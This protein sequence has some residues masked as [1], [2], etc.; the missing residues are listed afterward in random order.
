MVLGKYWAFIF[1]TYF[2]FNSFLCATDVATDTNKE[3]EEMETGL[4]NQLP[5]LRDVRLDGGH[6]DSEVINYLSSLQ[7]YQVLKLKALSENLRSA[8]ET[9]LKDSRRL[10][11]SQEI[12]SQ[13]KVVQES[14]KH[15]QK[16]LDKLASLDIA[17]TGRRNE[18][19]KSWH[20]IFA[21]RNSAFRAFVREVLVLYRMVQF[22]ENLSLA[23]AR[24]LL[25]THLEYV[26]WALKLLPHFPLVSKLIVQFFKPINAPHTPH[27][28]PKMH[29]V[30]D[31][32]GTGLMTIVPNGFDEESLR[33]FQE[34]G[35]HIWVMNHRDIYLDPYFV[36]QVL[37]NAGCGW[38][39]YYAVD[40]F[41]YLGGTMTFISEKIASMPDFLTVGGKSAEAIRRAKRIISH[42]QRANIFIF[43]EATTSLMG[44]TA[45][46]SPYFMLAFI[47]N[48][49]KAN[50]PGGIHL[51]VISTDIEVDFR[52][53]LKQRIRQLFTEQKA[54][55]LKYLGSIDIPD[56]ITEAEAFKINTIIWALIY[57]AQRTNKYH[58][59]GEL[60]YRAL[61]KSINIM[62]DKELG[63]KNILR[64]LPE[65]LNLHTH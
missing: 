10:N 23:N 58:I 50:I 32:Y 42:N 48:L 2:C 3:I 54:V 65:S 47:R 30:L 55:E 43:P 4:R 57:G 19:A 49:K 5:H 13:W 36:S 51:H 27:F 15:L 41:R 11:P 9:I 62:F 64:G 52:A 1:I 63:C 29:R 16:I 7:A 45:L 53:T 28:T 34:K 24:L 20:L 6:I 61:E 35:L 44:D 39:C 25:M 59:Q 46:F 14:Y 18:H 31:R 37:K 17:P 33:R 26:R 21:K 22:G 60:T 8:A 40:P 56:K 12:E 38:G